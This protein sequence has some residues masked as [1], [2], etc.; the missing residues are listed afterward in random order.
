MVKGEIRRTKKRYFKYKSTF[1]IRCFSAMVIFFLFCF[2]W[3]IQLDKLNILNEA[4]KFNCVV[5]FLL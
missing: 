3:P 4:L 5:E 2:V 1:K